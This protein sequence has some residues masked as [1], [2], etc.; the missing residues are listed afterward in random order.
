[1]V[2]LTNGAPVEIL[3]L[4]TGEWVRDNVVS[5]NRQ[6]FYVQHG[7]FDEFFFIWEEEGVNWKAI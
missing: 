3:N 2:K 4:E 6:G 5:T 7:I 1:M